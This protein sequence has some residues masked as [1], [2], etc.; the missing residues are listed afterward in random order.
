MDIN[1]FGNEEGVV[2]SFE[3]KNF[4][5]ELYLS[6]IL[7]VIIVI[8]QYYGQ[9]DTL[10]EDV[11]YFD[12]ID[13]IREKYIKEEASSEMV[14]K[15]NKTSESVNEQE[16]K[17]SG[18]IK[19]DIDNAISTFRHMAIESGECT[20]WEDNIHEKLGEFEERQLKDLKIVLQSKLEYANKPDKFDWK[21]IACN[22]IISV[23]LAF[24]VAT[25][26]IFNTGN[27]STLVFDVSSNI[28]WVVLVLIA[29]I[30]IKEHNQNKKTVMNTYAI[31]K[32][33]EITEDMEM[34]ARDK[35][36]M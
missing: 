11:R 31:K 18:Q 20:S 17:N 1:G 24:V 22:V 30:I 7:Y 14:K 25:Y 4:E 13:D 5:I 36:N 33:L 9:A 6:V 35:N 3:I 10:F 23:F 8:I 28:F 32:L 26:T 27:N 34:V 15:S 21:T 29:L 12:L 16:G 2:T 19:F